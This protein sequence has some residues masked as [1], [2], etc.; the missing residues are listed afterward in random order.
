MSNHKFKRYSFLQVHRQYLC[1]Y[2]LFVNTYTRNM[3]LAQFKEIDNDV[4]NSKILCITFTLYVLYTVQC[5]KYIPQNFVI[6]CILN[7]FLCLIR[8]LV[9]ENQFCTYY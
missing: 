6:H 1:V 2:K 3:N 8:I 5:Y 9:R 7:K 4:G